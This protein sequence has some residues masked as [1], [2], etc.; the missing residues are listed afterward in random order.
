MTIN[1]K[2]V[3]EIIK[4]MSFLHDEEVE[5]VT[6]KDK[7]NIHDTFYKYL[8]HP[9]LDMVWYSCPYVS[10]YFINFISK[11][12]VKVVLMIIDVDPPSY[13]LQ[14]ALKLMEMEKKGKINT[15]IVQRPK[16]SKF[17]HQK[18]FIP[19]YFDKKIKKLYPVCGFTGSVNLTKNGL[20]HNDE[21]LVIIRNHKAILK[22]LHILY[23]RA[24]TGKVL[25]ELDIKEQLLKKS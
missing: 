23:E 24:L 18:I 1:E 21:V 9:Y 22:L 3:Q 11:T 10:D 16:G 12:K 4:N 6:N 8:Q 15:I 25:S 14:S 5:I 2:F 19:I 13:T 20:L 17:L 7:M